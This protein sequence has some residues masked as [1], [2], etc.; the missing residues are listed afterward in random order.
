LP[1]RIALLRYMQ[2]V[3]VPLAIGTLLFYALAPIVD[4]MQRWHLPGHWAPSSRL[5]LVVVSLGALAYTLQGQ[6]SDSGERPSGGAR[7]FARRCRRPQPR[8]RP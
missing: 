5:G 4:G 6:A 8:R 3:F 7:R 1:S 2:E